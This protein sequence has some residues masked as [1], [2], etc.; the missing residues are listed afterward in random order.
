MAARDAGEEDGN[1]VDDDDESAAEIKTGD[2]VPE[3]DVNAARGLL[4]AEVGVEDVVVV[5]EVATF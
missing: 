1:G 4:V 5:V 3:A 2:P